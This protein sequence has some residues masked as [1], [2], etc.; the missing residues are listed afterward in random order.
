M[1]FLLKFCLYE[2]LCYINVFKKLFQSLT[3]PDIDSKITI[4]RFDRTEEQ[5]EELGLNDIK[6]DGYD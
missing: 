2:T 6:V 5:N 3:A 4:T 1:S